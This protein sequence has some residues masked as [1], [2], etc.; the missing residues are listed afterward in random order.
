[1]FSSGC[2]LHILPKKERVISTGGI[3]TQVVSYNDAPIFHQ[4]SG[5]R[6]MDLA[7]DQGKT[8]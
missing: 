1:M 5:S 3:L 8:Q 4:F 2:T 7:R 6:H